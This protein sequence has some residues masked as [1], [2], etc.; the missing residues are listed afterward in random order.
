MAATYLCAQADCESEYEISKGIEWNTHM[1]CTEDCADNDR[2]YDGKHPNM[3]CAVCE[4]KVTERLGHNVRERD[5][6]EQ[7]AHR[8]VCRTIG[9]TGS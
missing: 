6:L 7:Q 1:Y 4:K 2:C 3:S 8:I 9:K 5:T